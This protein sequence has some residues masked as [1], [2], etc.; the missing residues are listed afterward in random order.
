MEDFISK[1]LSDFQA[2]TS[3]ANIMLFCNPC[4]EGDLAKKIIEGIEHISTESDLF[5]DYGIWNETYSLNIF[6]LI[7]R[8]APLL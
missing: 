2:E 8:F 4:I 7:S 6:L 5:Y 3:F 1:E